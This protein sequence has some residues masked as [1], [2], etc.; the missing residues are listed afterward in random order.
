GDPALLDTR[1]HID[2]FLRE[3]QAGPSPPNRRALRDAFRALRG[4]VLR[5]EL[6]ARD[7]SSRQDRPYTVRELQY[8]LREIEPPPSGAEH[9]QRICLPQVRGERTTQWERGD[10]PQTRFIFTD[11]YDEFGQPRL[12]TT[13]A[14]P[15]GWQKAIDTPVAPYLA[16]TTLTAYGSP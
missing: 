7:G 3:R 5:T 2:A 6:Y 1:E 10:D 14:C 9:R 4:R 15:R 13:I 16:T 11:R 12:V 8:G